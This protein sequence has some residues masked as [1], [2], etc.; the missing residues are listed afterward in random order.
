MSQAD[1]I[2]TSTSTSPSLQ[3]LPLD[4]RGADDFLVA[5]AA[6]SVLRRK[7]DEGVGHGRPGVRRL[8]HV[9]EAACDRVPS[10]VALEC[11]G[12]RLTYGELDER[13]NR[14]AHLL[15]GRGVGEGARVAVLLPRSVEMYVVLLAVGKAGAAFVPID[16][17]APSDR[18]AY[19]AE[20]AGVD[21]LVT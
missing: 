21:L 6:A 5:S 12:R 18:V 16:P 14:L 13:A 2:G 15:R 10:A 17:E 7:G 20:D 3:D 4:G 11:G 9:F 1:A 8:H 19:I